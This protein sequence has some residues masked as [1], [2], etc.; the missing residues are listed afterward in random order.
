MTTSLSRCVAYFQ[1]E[2]VDRAGAVDRGAFTVELSAKPKASVS[3][4]ALVSVPAARIE[5]DM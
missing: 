5:L 4:S 3:K 2:F 1:A